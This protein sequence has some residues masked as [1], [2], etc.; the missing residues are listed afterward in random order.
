MYHWKMM[1]G[2]LAFAV[3]FLIPVKGQSLGKSFVSITS[4][5]QN[6]TN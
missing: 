4:T 6:Y 5:L 1:L 3:I 2:I